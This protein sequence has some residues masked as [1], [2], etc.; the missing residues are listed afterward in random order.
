MNDRTKRENQC[1]AVHVAS[2]NWKI[3]N[4]LSSNKMKLSPWLR[5]Q[6]IAFS[7]DFEVWDF[8]HSSSDRRCFQLVFVC[9]CVHQAAKTKKKKTTARD[10]PKNNRINPKKKARKHHKELEFLV[11]WWNHWGKRWR[12]EQNQ[13]D[14]ILSHNL[15]TKHALKSTP[16]RVGCHLSMSP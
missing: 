3:W 6:D 4:L 16:N 13:G 7:S 11:L 2:D 9:L 5:A 12:V 1:Y 8:S 15:T 10:Q 14:W